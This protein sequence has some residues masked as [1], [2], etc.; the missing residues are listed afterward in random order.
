MADVHAETVAWMDES[1]V[2]DIFEV[3]HNMSIVPLAGKHSQA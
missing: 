1:N 3:C 2:K